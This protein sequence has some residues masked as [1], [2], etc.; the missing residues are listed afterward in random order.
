MFCCINKSEIDIAQWVDNV[1]CGAFYFCHSYKKARLAALGWYPRTC[2]TQNV[3]MNIKKPEQNRTKTIIKNNSKEKKASQT[4]KCFTH[5]CQSDLKIY[6][7]PRYEWCHLI[8]LENPAQSLGR[9][10]LWAGSNCAGIV[11]ILHVNSMLRC[12]LKKGN[13]NDDFQVCCWR[14]RWV[15][16]SKGWHL[17]NTVVLGPS[18][19][20]GFL[21]E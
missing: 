10:K 7:K 11:S 18:Q 4:K 19:E 5:V 8:N 21:V 9:A 3:V 1:A 17:G 20:F 13:N 15:S 16:C 14:R 2:K 12:G 6:E